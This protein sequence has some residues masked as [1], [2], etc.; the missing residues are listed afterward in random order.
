MP[1]ET[2]KVKWVGIRPTNPA[3]N[4]P[5]ELFMPATQQVF[6]HEP[7]PWAAVRGGITRTQFINYAAASGTTTILR[8]V[9]SGKS[10]FIC[11]AALSLAHNTTSVSVLL[12][13]NETDTVTAELLFLVLS[14]VGHVANSISYPMPLK[15]PALYD[16]CVYNQLGA[17][18]AHITGWEE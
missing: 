3:E 8:T 4:I 6:Q 18:Y 5:V 1:G 14:G 16:I 13:R 9:T 7:G 10:Y 2:N 17:S 15:V 12:I 11:S